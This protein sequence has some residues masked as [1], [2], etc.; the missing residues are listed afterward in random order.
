[1]AKTKLTEP[2]IRLIDGKNFAN[3]AFMMEGGAPHVSPVW[4]DRD[5]DI[6]LLNTT[7]TGRVKSKYLQPGSKVAISI[8]DQN[9]PYRNVLIRGKVSERTKTGASEHID[10]MAKKYLNLDK[11]PDHKPGI[12]RVILRI[13]P[14][15]VSKEWS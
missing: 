12:D 14:E 5:G 1:M 10:K 2:A 15:K 7:D 11:Y 3:V 6:V 9:N 8:F 4:V 13:E